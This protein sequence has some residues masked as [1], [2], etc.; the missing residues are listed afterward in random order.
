MLAM[1][2]ATC[3]G[4][5]TGSN[6]GLSLPPLQP[7]FGKLEDNQW[8]DNNPNSKA[9]RNYFHC[10]HQSHTQRNSS[11]LTHTRK[12]LEAILLF[13]SRSSRDWQHASLFLCGS[14]NS[15]GG[16]TPSVWGIEAEPLSRWL[17][18]SVSHASRL[19]SSPFNWQILGRSG[20]CFSHPIIKT[21]EFKN[22]SQMIK[23]TQLKKRQGT[24]NVCKHEDC[25]SYPTL[26]KSDVC[27][28][29]FLLIA[30]QHNLSSDDGSMTWW[31]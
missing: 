12:G 5:T 8:M 1:M 22:W 27:R 15:H 3:A 17:N 20:M 24:A 31:W 2:S 7:G 10:V 16:S 21:L 9:K 13:D 26:T 19:Y 11:L 23:I 29:F 4:D 25:L 6:S 14:L 30:A 28:V 18:Y